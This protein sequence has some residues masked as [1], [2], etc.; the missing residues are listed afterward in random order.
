[1]SVPP[2]IAGLG[3][4]SVK[5]RPAPGFDPMKAGIGPEEYFVFSRIDGAQSIKDV[6]L[7]TGLPTDRGI[8]ILTKLRSIGAVLLPGETVAPVGTGPV[9]SR[10]ATPVAARPPMT[11]RTATPPQPPQ[12][13][14]APVIA[15]TMTPMRPAAVD[16]RTARGTSAG[17]VPVEVDPPHPLDLSLSDPSTD[18]LLA[19]AEDVELD[20]TERRKILAIARLVGGRD[21]HALLGV[22]VGADAKALKRAYFKLSKDVHPDRF[23][24]KRLGSFAERLSTVFEAVSRA[25]TRLTEPQTRSSS[26]QKV[27]RQNDQPQTPV[28]YAAELFD[29]ACGLEVSGDALGAMKMFAAAVRVDPQP[30]YLRRS[31]TCA[32][33]AGQ[34]KTALEYAKKAQTQTPDDPSSARLLATTFRAVGKLADAEEVLVMA[35]AMKSGNDVLG[36]ELRNDLAEVRRLL[37]QS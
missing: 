15:R 17:E 13:G 22:K 29:R 24:G 25:Y 3:P 23:Y 26:T 20:D 11:Q 30:R 8:Q 33:T 27:A 2:D 34:P 4:T 1:M 16:P 6:L 12:R 19:M 28:E 31:A 9:V 21:P 37:S 36:N 7:A 14:S 18:E 35:M 5:L 32:L 10:T